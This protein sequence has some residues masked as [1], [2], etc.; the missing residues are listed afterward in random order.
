[1]ISDSFVVER[2]GAFGGQWLVDG[3]STG[4]EQPA[5]DTDVG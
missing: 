3:A 4:D 2:D 5:A 1:M